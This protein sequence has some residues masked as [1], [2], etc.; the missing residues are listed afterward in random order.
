MIGEIDWQSIKSIWEQELWPGRKDIEPQSAMLY[1]SGHDMINFIL[2]TLYLG[3]IED[4]VLLGVNSGHGCGDGSYR[5]RGLWVH[6][7]LRGKGIG[8]DLLK[9][10]IARGSELGSTFCWSFPRKTS[11][12]AYQCAGFHLTSDWQSSDT[13]VA[14]AFCKIDFQ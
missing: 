9:A 1:L 10:T 2:P 4:G 12:S 13:S 3:Y 5:S 14:N 7:D 11:W 6:P 8:T